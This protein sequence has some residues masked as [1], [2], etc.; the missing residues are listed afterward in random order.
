MDKKTLRK[1]YKTLRKD[2]TKEEKNN[3]DTN[4]I[5][6]VLNMEQYKSCNTLLCFVSTK[7]EINTHPLINNALQKGKVVAVPYCTNEAKVMDFY[8]IKSINDLV[9][10]TMDILEPNPKIHKKLIDFT[11]AFCVVPGFCFDEKGYRI[12]YGGGY[13]DVF[14]SKHSLL[15]VGICYDYG[16]VKKL[17]YDDY[18]I[19]VD[20]IVTNHLVYK[21]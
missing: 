20:Y 3:K 6:N 16:K 13:Y 8:I 17:K 9:I 1:K 10:R 11:N 12:G 15:K 14:L 7:E 18:D 4:I 5:N 19:P 2:L 21:V